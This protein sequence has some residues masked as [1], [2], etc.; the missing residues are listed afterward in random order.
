MISIFECNYNENEEHLILGV[1]DNNLLI[2]K[3]GIKE[4]H[5]R[6]AIGEPIEEENLTAWLIFDFSI[7]NAGQETLDKT[8]KEVLWFI[9]NELEKNTPFFETIKIMPETDEIAK[10]AALNGFIKNGNKEL[11][12]TR[13]KNTQIKPQKQKNCLQ[14]RAKKP[15]PNVNVSSETQI[16]ILQYLV[17]NPYLVSILQTSIYKKTGINEQLVRAAIKAFHKIGLIEIEKNGTR[18]NIYPNQQKIRQKL[19]E[20]KKTNNNKKDDGP[21]G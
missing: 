11:I 13:K 4:Q 20:L 15:A 10:A 1:L 12:L 9:E 18:H 7:K 21:T 2:G 14:W 3:I 6:D 5:H 17:K 19:E 16:A 8:I